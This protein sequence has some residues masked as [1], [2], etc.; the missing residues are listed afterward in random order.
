MI[1]IANDYG[2]LL[3]PAQAT[4][5][6]ERFKRIRAAYRRHQ[7]LVD[8]GRASWFL[9]D[10]YAIADWVM[11]FTPI[12]AAAWS[13]IR[14]AGIPL[15]PQLPVGRFFVDFG[16][17]VA[18]VALECDGA[19]WHQ[20]SAKDEA[21]DQELR[22]MGWRVYRASG[23]VCNVDFE[24]PEDWD[25]L[26]PEKRREWE[27]HV[28]ANSLKPILHSIKRECEVAGAMTRKGKMA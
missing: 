18:K 4:T 9:D 10:P 25:A 16:N 19:A 27:E 13:D 17:P 22:N 20:D 1:D 8:H 24:R 12:E 23:S 14:Y 28:E 15:W 21:R 7:E 5:I 2:D 11:I 6:G 26:T 3:P